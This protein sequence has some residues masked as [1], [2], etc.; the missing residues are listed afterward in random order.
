MNVFLWNARARNGHVEATLNHPFPAQAFVQSYVGSDELDRDGVLNG[1]CLCAAA[2]RWRSALGYDDA[3]SLHEGEF[4]A[5]V[6]YA[7]ANP[8]NFVALGAGNG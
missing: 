8:T 3:G 5:F 2:L 6:A 7:L 1:V 4:A